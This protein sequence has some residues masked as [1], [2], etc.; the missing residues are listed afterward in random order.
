MKKSHIILLATLVVLLVVAY[1]LYDTLAPQTSVPSVSSTITPQVLETPTVEPAED[2]VVEE[3][4]VEEVP[5]P[6]EEPTSE[7]ELTPAV[8][9]PFTNP[10]GTEVNL[11][12]FYGKPIVLNFWASWCPP[13]QSEMPDFQ[14]AYETY[15][16][17][18]HFIML[19]ATDGQ[20]ETME[21][22]DEFIVESGY[23]FPYYYDIGTYSGETYNQ[24]GS[25]IYGISSLPT[26]VFLDADGN[27]TYGQVGTISGQILNSQIE[28][29]LN[30]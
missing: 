13:C 19:N 22:A 27:I 10:D 16:Q 4:A 26:T 24:L 21:S 6:E 2:V 5:A 12:D 29:L 18:V 9:F 15:G 25:Y 28:A 14:T 30:P 1:F 7:E 11:S 20:R 3:T 23:S 8:D 17:D